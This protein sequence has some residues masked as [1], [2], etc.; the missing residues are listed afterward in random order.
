MSWMKVVKSLLDISSYDAF[1]DLGKDFCPVYIWRQKIRY[2][3]L[4]KVTLKYMIKITKIL[5]KDKNKTKKI[6]ILNADKCGI[7]CNVWRHLHFLPSLPPCLP[8]S[9][10]F[11]FLPTFS[12]LCL[13]FFSLPHHLYLLFLSFIFAFY[14]SLSL[15]LIHIHTHISVHYFVHFS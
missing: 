2:Y 8:F 14:P 10:F 3:S 4:W 1:S 6:C 12:L 7:F 13:P 15:L 9:F 11:S 5:F